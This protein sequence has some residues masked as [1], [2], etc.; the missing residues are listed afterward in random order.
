MAIWSRLIVI[1]VSLETQ[2]QCVIAKLHGPARLTPAMPALR[3]PQAATLA[4]VPVQRMRKLAGI[5]RI[6]DPVVSQEGELGC[7]W[8]HQA[9]LQHRTG[10]I[11]GG[12]MDPGGSLKKLVEGPGGEAEERLIPELLQ[13]VKLG[14]DYPESSCQGV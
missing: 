1:F 4:I 12:D 13:I 14:R 7:R 11:V 5:G 6:N 2:T 10:A 3:Q 9:V 8:N